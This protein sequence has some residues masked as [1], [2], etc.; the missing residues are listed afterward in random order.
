[1]GAVRPQ[2]L[3]QPALADARLAGDEHELRDTA[4]GGAPGRRQLGALGR[5]PYERRQGGTAA[6]RPLVGVDQQQRLV[7]GPGR[8]R[9]LD[10]ELPLGGGG[11]RVV[12]AHRT[13]AVAACVVQAHQCAVG[14]LA[15][16]VGAHEPLGAADRRRPVLAL[17][18]LFLEPLE[19]IEVEAA[20]PLALL[21]HPLV[22]AALDQV[23]GIGLDRRLQAGVGDRLL[24]V[25]EVELEG[26]VGAP[27]QRARGDLEEALGV[28]ELAAEGVEDLAQVRARLRLRRVRPQH[29]RQP[30]PGLCH[31]AMHE[32]MA[33]QRLGPSRLER[34]RDSADAQVH[35]A[36]K[37]DV[38]RRHPP[39]VSG[40]TAARVN[41]AGRRRR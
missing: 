16:G 26:R 15:Q 24:E 27:A 2:L 21:E 33:E 32:Q 30:L 13:R 10:A 6:R 25:R 17:L 18:Q 39:I 35:V 41:G 22:V 28:R 8:R 9:R 37:A 20:Q 40:R 5:P 7:G 31:A 1:M 14:V 4:G 38:K 19:G 3:D 29:E 23:A 11:E 34:H 12:G 36:E